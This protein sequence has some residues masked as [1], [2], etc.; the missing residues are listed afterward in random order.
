[1]EDTQHT[2]A[3]Y[4]RW[5]TLDYLTQVVGGRENNIDRN[6]SFRIPMSTFYDSR[7]RY[8]QTNY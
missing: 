7:N 3:K 5:K 2:L 4:A 8:W 6:L 1:M